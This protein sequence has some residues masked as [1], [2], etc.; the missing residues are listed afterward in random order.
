MA[1]NKLTITDLE[2]DD[3][4][5][6]LKTY[7]KAQNQFSD[8]DFDGSGMDVLIDILAYNTHY[9]GYYANMAVNEMF[10]DSATLRESIVSHAKHLNVIPSSVK[11]PSAFLNMTFTT[12]GS[13]TSITIKK[14]TKFTTSVNSVS[15][16]FVTPTATT[17]API[18]GVYSINNLEIKEGTFINSRFIVNLANTNQRFII[19]NQ[20]VDISTITVKIENSV[21]DSTI[22]TWKNANDLDVTTIAS[23]QK[24]FFIQEVEDQQ[25]EILFGDDAVGKALTDGNVIYIEYLTTNGIAANKASSF[26]AVGQVADLSSSNFSITGITAATGGTAVESSISVKRNAPKLYQ[27]QKRATTKEDYKAILLAERPDIES[28]TVYGGEDASPAVYGKVFIAIKPVGNTAY[29]AATKDVIKTSILDKTNVVTVIPEIVDP[30]FYYIII[31]AT[32]NYDPVT[33]LT[34]EDTLKTN[35]NT[36]INNYFSGNVEKFDSKFRYSVL[37]KAIDDTNNSIRNS[38][39]SIKYQQRISP[40]TLGVAATYNLE[41]NTTLEKGT[42]TSTVFQ[43]S[44]GNTYTLWDNS[45]GKVRLVKSTYNSSTGAVTIDVPNVFFVLPSGSTDLGTI[46]YTTGKVVM[47]SFTPHAI[48]DGTTNIKVTVTP[49]TNNQDIT[50]L[51]EQ[52]ITIDTDDTASVNITMVSETII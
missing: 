38:K 41:F 28:I 31:D 46:D 12:S 6:N 48:S 36:S 20:N 5:S 7:L 23:T 10:L 21:N 11:A 33:L 17:I 27:A 2:F 26:T 19:P 9:M 40:E 49:G 51:R 15:Y 50:P 4:K 16:T 39:T 1:S 37:T 30:I 13:P 3:I 24:V 44:D 32:V 45:A 34:N 25:Y 29:S 18:G 22:V 47:N 14:G 35:I 8:Y 42:L 52:I 43:A